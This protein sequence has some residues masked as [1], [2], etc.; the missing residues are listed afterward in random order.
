VLRT[1]TLAFV[2]VL[3]LG[4][5]CGPPPPPP[6]PPL[7]PQTAAALLHYDNRAKN[8]LITIRRRD[9]SCDYNLTLPD[10]A[11]HPTVIDLNHIVSCGGRPSPREFDASVSFEYDRNQHAW[12]I[13][14]FSS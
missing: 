11:S 6:I 2:A 4:L 7:T 14:R 13:R 3:A 1:A 10:Q 9:P 8:W 5:A 12:V